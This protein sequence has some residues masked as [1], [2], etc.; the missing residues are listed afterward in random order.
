MIRSNLRHFRRFKS[1]KF[2]SIEEF[3]K[4]KT[5]YSYGYNFDSL[6]DIDESIQPPKPEPKD[7]SMDINQVLEKD[8]RLLKLK[9]GSHEYR[10]TLHQL[11]QEFLIN[12]KKQH[13]RFEFNERMK[14]VFFGLVALIGV[15]SAHQIFMNRKSIKNRLLM[16]YKYGDV[17]DEPPK[18]VKNV[19][20]TKHLLEKLEKELS[21]VNL[22]NMK[23][24]QEPGV[25]YFGDNV[26]IPVRIPEFDGVY[27][28]DAYVERNNIIAITDKGKVL[29]W[30]KGSLKQLELPNNVIKIA[31]TKDNY[32]FLTS[33]GE[34][35]YIPRKIDTGFIPMLKRNWFGMLK[36]QSFSKVQNV[37]NISQVCSGVDHLLLL[38]KTGQ[39]SVIN[40]SKNPTNYGQYGPTYSPFDKKKIP[41]NEIIDLPI[42]NYQLDST[43]A[44][45]ERKFD[46][47]ASGDYYNIISE[48][49]SVWSWGDNKFGQCGIN[50][51]I[52]TIP[53]P[54]E[55]FNKKDLKRILKT[56]IYEPLKVFAGP[57]TS[58]LLLDNQY[59]LAFGSGI[60]G[61][62]GSGRYLQVCSYPEIVKGQWSSQEFDEKTNSVKPIGI[63]EISVGNHHLLVQINSGDILATGSN[64]FGQL[65]NGKKIKSCKTVN[66]PK[67]LE[68]E[69]GKD[70]L[71]LA[72]IINDT[73]TKRLQLQNHQKFLAGNDASIIYSCK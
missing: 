67:L 34:I 8:P 24:S 66:I 56:K 51:S 61:E 58:Y 47:I 31:P 73:T 18:P 25:Y 57:S 15:V 32:Y 68:P 50:N 26:K 38:N 65:G 5:K 45:V 63:K 9:P 6:K 53:I 35:L 13:K 60:N 72:Q 52:T 20:S 39:V 44:L 64:D 40:T 23:S 22:A 70:K 37:S 12:S 36:I 16:N 21:D 17:I 71:K 42:L 62:L 48:K 54:K 55:V 49:N 28:K 33:S 1:D 3:N 59:L 4:K 11:H 43:G 10:E 27:I 29:Q 41:I 2:S 69:D 46:S 30:Q 19:K 14:G 7:D